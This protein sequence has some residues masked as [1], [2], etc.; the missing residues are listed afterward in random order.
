MRITRMNTNTT[1]TGDLNGGT[2]SFRLTEE[3]RRTLEERASKEERTVSNFV[4][5]LAYAQRPSV[6]L[7]SVNPS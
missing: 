2:I 6:A 4:R 3:E 7:R 1:N 5:Q